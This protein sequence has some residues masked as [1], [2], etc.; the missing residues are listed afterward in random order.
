MIMTNFIL[1]YRAIST[2]SD[3]I[4]LK[5]IPQ[6]QGNMDSEKIF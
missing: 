6:N 1:K 2:S 3:R 5:N 4:F